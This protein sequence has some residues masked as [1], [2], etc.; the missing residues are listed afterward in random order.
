M[1]LVVDR[2]D[3]RTYRY[4]LRDLWDRHEMLWYCGTADMLGIEGLGHHWLCTTFKIQSLL[5]QRVRKIHDDVELLICSTNS[6]SDRSGSMMM[7]NSIFYSVFADPRGWIWSGTEGVLHY[8]FWGNPCRA[9]NDLFWVKRSDILIV[10]GHQS[11]WFMSFMWM[12]CSKFTSI[13][14]AC[15]WRIHIPAQLREYVR[16]VDSCLDVRKRWK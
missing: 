14:P 4:L 11:T 15:E 10:P 9:H 2:L 1:P 8:A 13:R 5:C 7:D 16:M 12:T 6:I 3:F